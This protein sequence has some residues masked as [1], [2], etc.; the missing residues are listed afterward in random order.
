MLKPPS[1]TRINGSPYMVMIRA[2]A[3]ENIWARN[4][5]KLKGRSKSI[6]YRSEENLFRSRPIGVESKNR[7]YEGR[8]LIKIQSR[9]MVG[10]VQTITVA[11]V[12]R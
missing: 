12:M 7:I 3:S 6:V 8:E 1:N 2:P 9:D 10:C 5:F 4:T 11:R